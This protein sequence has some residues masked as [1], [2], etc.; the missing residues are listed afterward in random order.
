MGPSRSG[1]LR[2]PPPPI[3]NW[4]SVVIVVEVGWGGGAVCEKFSGILKKGQDCL[5]AIF[6]FHFFSADVNILSYISVRRLNGLNG[7][8]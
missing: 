6:K 4:C 5:L 3:L 8:G 1:S 2:P 7:Y